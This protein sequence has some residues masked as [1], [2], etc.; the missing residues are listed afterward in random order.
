M[1]R[2]CS[3][4]LLE[5]GVFFGEEE[6]EG[7]VSWILFEEKAKSNLNFIR[8]Q[9]KNDD[10][11]KKNIQIV[12][13]MMIHSVRRLTPTFYVCIS[14]QQQKIR[15]HHLNY[16][17]VSYSKCEIGFIIN[18][19]RRL[20]SKIVLKQDH[21]ILKMDI[22]MMKNEIFKMYLVD[23]NTISMLTQQENNGENISVLDDARME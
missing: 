14:Q 9:N 21:P 13:D 12:K 18:R 7:R 6:D 20:L 2:I 23:S 22:N 19:N 11:M 3:V 15:C 1:K 10:D 17:N 5:V 8:V 4:C 16:T